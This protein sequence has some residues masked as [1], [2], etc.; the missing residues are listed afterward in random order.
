[1]PRPLSNDLR[2]RIVRAVDDGLSRNAT[3]KRFDVSVSAV[4]KLIQQWRATGSYL[5]KRIGGYR[6]RL[7]ADHADRVNR[8]VTEKPDMTVAEMQQQLAA[9]DIKAGPSAIARF[10]VY[11]GHTYKKNSSRQRARSTRR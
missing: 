4:V 2:E 9:A 7:L 8:L 11:L 10:L 6:K 5:P 1:M 3:A